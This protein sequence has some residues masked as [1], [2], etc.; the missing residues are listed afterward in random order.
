MTE[1]CT[2]LGLSLLVV[3]LFETDLLPVFRICSGH[4]DGATYPL[5]HPVSFA[6]VPL[7]ACICTIENR[8]RACITVLGN[9][10][11]AAH[12]CAD[13]GQL[14]SLL[15]LYVHHFWLYGDHSDALS[16][17]HLSLPATLSG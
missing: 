4:S 14:S 6:I 9:V 15:S 13:D 10:S 16:F 5:Y 3:V 8:S 11:D 17:L 2:A 1:F 7:Q 12:L